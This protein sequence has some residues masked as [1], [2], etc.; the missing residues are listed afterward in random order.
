ML[1][2]IKVKQPENL[3]PTLFDKMINFGMCTELSSISSKNS[4]NIW[5][6]RLKIIN[7]MKQKAVLIVGQMSDMSSFT[8][9]CNQNLDQSR[10]K[11]EY[12]DQYSTMVPL[13]ME[14]ESVSPIHCLV[15]CFGPSPST[16]SKLSQTTCQ[17]PSYKSHSKPSPVHI[18]MQS[19]MMV[20]IGRW[21]CLYIRV[22]CK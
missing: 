20:A 3:N 7:M 21:F 14:A 11:C 12:E 4:S 9:I 10:W 22:C 6:P 5:E 1:I 19:I 18:F 8:E 15:H 16:C 2:N 17:K 13:P